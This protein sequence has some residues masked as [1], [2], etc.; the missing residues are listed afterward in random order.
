MRDF[1]VM[2]DKPLMNAAITFTEPFPI[3]LAVTLCPELIARRPVRQ[4]PVIAPGEVEARRHDAHN[5]QRAPVHE[6][7]M[8]QAS[9]M[10]AAAASAR[11]AASERRAKRRS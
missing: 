3:G 4:P 6:E 1:K 5:R 2:Y 9:V 11:D 7:R 10:M 8:P